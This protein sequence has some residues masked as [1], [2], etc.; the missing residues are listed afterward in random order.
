MERSLSLFVSGVP[1]WCIAFSNGK[2]EELLN[3]FYNSFIPSKLYYNTGFSC[4]TNNV[5]CGMAQ[6]KLTWI[7]LRL[8]LENAIN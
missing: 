4:V 2:R 1:S 5:H 6:A 7:T 3:F 8:R